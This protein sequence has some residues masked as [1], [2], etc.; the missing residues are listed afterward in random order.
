M[1]L[2]QELSVVGPK[3]SLGTDGRGQSRPRFDAA[4]VRVELWQGNCRH[5]TVMREHADYAGRV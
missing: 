3:I 4:N 1:A 5:A 2:A